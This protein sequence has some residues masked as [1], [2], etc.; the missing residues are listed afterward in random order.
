MPKM[1]PIPLAMIALLLPL[2]LPLLVMTVPWG[3]FIPPLLY[4]IFPVTSIWFA[5]LSICRGVGQPRNVVARRLSA[6][7]LLLSLVESAAIV[8]LLLALAKC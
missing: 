3:R 8:F 1:K 4:P 7:A 2:G 6:V 5:C